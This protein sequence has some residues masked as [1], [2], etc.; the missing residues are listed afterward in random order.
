MASGV[1]CFLYSKRF[2]CES[3][4]VLVFLGFDFP[5]TLSIVYECHEQ[6]QIDFL[7]RKV[8]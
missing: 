5:M 8:Y 4:G 1:A 2:I 6:R 7:S 3:C